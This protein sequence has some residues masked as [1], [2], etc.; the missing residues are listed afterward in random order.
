MNISHE[1]W[2]DNSVSFV[3][4][5][6][7]ARKITTRHHPPIREIHLF[8][9]KKFS[10]ITLSLLSVRHFRNEFYD[11][12]TLN[13]LNIHSDV[14][15]RVGHM[16]Y[17]RDTSGDSIWYRTDVVTNKKSR[18]ESK[19]DNDYKWYNSIVRYGIMWTIAWSN[20]GRDHTLAG[21]DLDTGLVI[22]I[23]RLR[24]SSF[25]EMFSRY[26][27]TSVFDEYVTFESC[28][29]KYSRVNIND[30]KVIQ[31]SQRE[32]LFMRPRFDRRIAEPSAGLFVVYLDRN[33]NPTRI[34]IGSHQ[35]WGS[36]STLQ[37]YNVCNVNDIEF[38]AV[39]YISSIAN[40][41]NKGRLVIINTSTGEHRDVVS[42]SD[43]CNLYTIKESE[44]EP[45]EMN[46]WPILT[47]QTYTNRTIK[48]DVNRDDEKWKLSSTKR[49]ELPNIAMWECN[50]Y[51]DVSFTWYL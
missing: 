21:I 17:S 42:D 34:H 24:V 26:R 50:N 16:I 15:W 49:T 23:V 13:K 22:K 33:N 41:A 7:G 35:C 10:Y 3:T 2:N 40:L 51:Y 28:E 38:I 9:S 36:C 27:I 39:G 1:L 20:G 45:N 25:G 4:I 8:K 44:Y 48:F 31:L 11:I 47:C 12:A 14:F 5:N 19:L 30:G 18:I 43:L 6:N 29:S 37:C 32:I 46:K